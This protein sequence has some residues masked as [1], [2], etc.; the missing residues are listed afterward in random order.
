MCA[1]ET[2]HS[3][4]G[5]TQCDKNASDKNDLLP[6]MTLYLTNPMMTLYLIHQ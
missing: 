4:V 6:K 5:V 1:S 3:I 2:Q